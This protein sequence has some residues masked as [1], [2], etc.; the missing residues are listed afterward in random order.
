MHPVITIIQDEV[1]DGN[2]TNLPTK[3]EDKQELHEGKDSK[4][5]GEGDG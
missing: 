5:Q 4:V 3:E 1:V 2:P